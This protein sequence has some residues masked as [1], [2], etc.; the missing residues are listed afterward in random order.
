MDRL[1]HGRTSL[2]RI[3]RLLGSGRRRAHVVGVGLLRR[4]LL[5]V[6]LGLLDVLL[7]LL[8][9]ILLL[10]LRHVVE[11]LRRGRGLAL[12][13]RGLRLGMGIV[14]VRLS[15]LLRVRLGRLLRIRLRRLLR[16]RLAVCGAYCC[17][18]YWV[19]SE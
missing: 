11:L 18:A 9:L 15:R 10:L 2:L 1:R 17:G 5:D 6:L 12:R 19:A 13:I 16:V 3:V 4:L 14:A 7:G 8:L